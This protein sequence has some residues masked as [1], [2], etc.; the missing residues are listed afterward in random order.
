MLQ[1]WVHHY[2]VGAARQQAQ[3]SGLQQLQQ[4][5]DTSVQ[6]LLLAQREAY[7]LG[8]SLRLAATS[9]AVNDVLAIAHLSADLDGRLAP[10][11]AV[12]GGRPA[13]AEE[14]AP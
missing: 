13:D 1:W 6:L 3:C 10:A 7:Q 9:Q 8:R 11:G 5:A 12:A 2:K 14:T 4:A